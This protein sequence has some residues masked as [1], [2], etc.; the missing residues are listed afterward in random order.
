MS[1]SSTLRLV[2]L[3]AMA[4]ALTEAA[5]STRLKLQ[6]P[7]TKEI[8]IPVKIDQD[9]NRSHYI[10]QHKEQSDPGSGLFSESRGHIDNRLVHL[11]I[12]NGKDCNQGEFS[13]PPPTVVS[14]LG[15]KG[16]GLTLTSASPC[17]VSKPALSGPR[18]KDL[19]FK[20]NHKNS[21]DLK[22]KTIISFAI[23][24]D[25]PHI[26]KS[27]IIDSLRRVRMN[28]TQLIAG[29]NNGVV[30]GN[31]HQIH[32]DLKSKGIEKITFVK[33]SGMVNGTYVLKAGEKKP[34]DSELSVDCCNESGDAPAN[35]SDTELHLISN[36]VKLKS[37]S[38]LLTNTKLKNMCWK[39]NIVGSPIELGPMA[40]KTESGK[41]CDELRRD[42]GKKQVLLEKR[43]DALLR[44]LKR[45][46]SKVVETHTKEQLVQY[47]NFQHR[48]LQMVAK[49]IKNE[50]PGPEELKEH[51][52]SNEEVKNMSTSQLVKLVRGYKGSKPLFSNDTQSRFR[53]PTNAS[54]MSTSVANH[55]LH[56]A[57]RL[58]SKV[59][60]TEGDLDSDA[61]ASSSGGESGDEDS[62]SLPLN[63]DVKIPPM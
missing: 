20:L 61:T 30:S 57:E 9:L 56:I 62:V 59:Q 3:A 41:S 44:R 8:S 40:N 18:L 15:G 13:R 39:D 46:K 37:N 54:I 2:C 12:R 35:K 63:P 58:H 22:D 42:C 32:S 19:N 60:A 33:H 14:G 16:V 11:S 6:D 1:G 31:N 5:S 48:N 4:P 49:T 36:P 17:I 55:C 47:V 51:F 43:V 25:S 53:S 10:S 45:I 24:K 28:K 50:A 34:D 26:S 52:L 27:D 21:K 23:S 29:K 38:V 7:S